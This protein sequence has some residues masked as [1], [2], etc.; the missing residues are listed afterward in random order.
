[1][2]GSRA[3]SQARTQGA[4]VADATDATEDD[5]WRRVIAGPEAR[6]MLP[7]ERHARPVT[8]PRFWVASTKPGKD[9]GS[10]RS[11]RYGRDRGRRMAPRDR[12]ARS[13]ED[14]AGRATCS[15]G[16]IAAL[17]GREHQARQGRRERS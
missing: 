4:F 3:P 2:S 16:D 17:L 1:A 12:G 8:L 9:A 7:D 6:R 13:T 5:A 11:R 15:S 14:V 10:V